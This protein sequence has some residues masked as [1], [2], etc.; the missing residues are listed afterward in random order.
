MK[1]TLMELILTIVLIPFV[2]AVITGMG[3][4]LA[5]WIK[6]GWMLLMS[7]KIFGG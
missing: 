3:L 4:L 1:Y 6:W 5:V 7:D 2:L